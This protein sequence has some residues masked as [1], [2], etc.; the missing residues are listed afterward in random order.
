MLASTR[1]SCRTFT[2]QTYERDDA[3]YCAF[4]P[5]TPL[6]S[7]VCVDPTRHVKLVQRL[8]A[9]ARRAARLGLAFFAARGRRGLADAA[10]TASDLRA[11]TASSSRSS[12]ASAGTVKYD[13]LRSGLSGNGRKAA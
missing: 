9:G 10:A 12:S 1:E 2:A 8:R 7:S 4:T 13:M 5:D 3:N 11:H 6:A